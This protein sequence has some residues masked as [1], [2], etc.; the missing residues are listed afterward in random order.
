[1]RSEIGC[2]AFAGLAAAQQEPAQD[3]RS[4]QFV[5]ANYAK[6]DDGRL[7]A[8]GWKCLLD[9]HGQRERQASLRYQAKPRVLGYDG[10]GVAAFAGVTTTNIKRLRSGNRQNR[11]WQNGG[12]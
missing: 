6:Q 4:Y 12:V 1:M 10:I 11:H 5:N 2:F 3:Y 7:I 9:Q 8:E